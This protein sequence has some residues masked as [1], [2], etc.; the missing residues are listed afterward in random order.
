MTPVIA[1]TSLSKSFE[2]K[3]GT[4]GAVREVSFRVAPGEVVGL[5]GPNGAGKTTTMRM[6]STLERPTRG[7]AVV[8][9]HDLLRDA[10]GVRRSIGLVAQSGGTRPIATPRD[11]LLLQARIH[12][13]AEPARR[14]QAMI[15]TFDLADLADRPTMTLSGGQRRR[16]D[17]AIGLI[18]TPAVLFL[19]EPTAALDPPSR[20]EMW[21]H[22]RNLRRRAAATVVLSTHHLDEADAL[23]DRVLILDHGRLVAEDSPARLKRQL[24][25]DVLTVALTGD[26]G[27][28]RDA[29]GGLPGVRGV[30]GDGNEL[31]IGCQNADE[32]VS[33]VVLALH[34]NRVE[35]RGLRV[36]HPS[37]DDVFLAL[38]GHATHQ[39][40]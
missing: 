30:H 28:A 16:L 32:L 10:H 5:L 31:R 3:T 6:L 40:V 36:A 22:I 29:V 23:C 18:H 4:V 25:D 35:V 2:T 37:L 26:A 8:A 15:D 39:E 13:L 27:R 24:G 11:E 19:D 38:T 17:V 1:A 7:S 20:A 33:R 9:G 12:R 14:A 21:Q 34:D